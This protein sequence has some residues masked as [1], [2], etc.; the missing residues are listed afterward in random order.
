[1]L[2]LDTNWAHWIYSRLAA[3]GISAVVTAAGGVIMWYFGFRKARLDN[4]KLALELQRLRMEL[5]KLSAD[6][7]HQAEERRAAAV[8]SRIF[9]LAR[10]R[11]QKAH[12]PGNILLREGELA[13]TLEEPAAIV[14]MALLGLRD[15]GFVRYHSSSDSWL[16]L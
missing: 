12:Y 14:R 4:E 3:V 7:V 9:E 2:T 16:V 5:Q 13:K 10:E 8:S 15:K 11:K 1:M 6:E